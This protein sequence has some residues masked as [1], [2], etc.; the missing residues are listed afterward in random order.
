MLNIVFHFDPRRCFIA[1][2]PTTGA[3]TAPLDA[4][5]ASERRALLELG[6]LAGDRLTLRECTD[7]SAMQHYLPLTQATTDGIKAALRAR[8]EEIA[9]QAEENER[10]L[11]DKAE[12]RRLRDEER[13]RKAEELEPRIAADIERLKAGGDCT[14]S[15]STHTGSISSEAGACFAARDLIGGVELLELVATKNA[16]LKAREQAKRAERKQLADALMEKLASKLPAEVQAQR[17]FFRA[18][19]YLAL[20]ARAQIEELLA[21]SACGLTVSNLIAE[22]Y[23]PLTR[24]AAPELVAAYTKLQTAVED[25]TKPRQDEI[26]SCTVAIVEHTNRPDQAVALVL[27]IGDER[28]WCYILTLPAAPAGLTPSQE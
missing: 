12:E 7:T 19:A 15:L 24:R 16:A 5:S 18:S 10:A 28:E 1:G 2:V 6:T 25:W 3:L 9:R 27:T 13:K 14:L 8:A 11:K 20:A 22:A 21:S 17:P 23:G 26:A 4:F